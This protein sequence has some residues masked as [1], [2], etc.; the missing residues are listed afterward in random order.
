MDHAMKIMD[1]A[2]ARLRA[3]S[4]GA[5]PIRYT[6]LL[7]RSRMRVKSTHLSGCLPR[8]GPAKANSGGNG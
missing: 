2:R 6:N 4:E 7:D 8:D 5:L 3:W 1:G